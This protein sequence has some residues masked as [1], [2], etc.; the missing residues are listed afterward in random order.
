M[1]FDSIASTNYIIS[2]INLFSGYAISLSTQQ[3][4]AIVMIIFLTIINIGGLSMGKLIQNVFTLT[5]TASLLALILLGLF[6]GGRAGVFSANWSIPFSAADAGKVVPDLL[7]SL[8]PMSIVDGILGIVVVLGV[9]QVG[10]LFS[11]DAWNN[12]TFTAGE[13]KE[14]KRTIPLS[15]VLGTGLVLTLYVLANLAYLNTLPLADIQTTPEDRVG[16]AALQVIFGGVGAMIMAYA[17]V[18][19]TFGCNNGLI[20]SGARVYYA[21]AKD[22]LFFRKTG[23]LNDNHVPAFAL[24]LQCIWACVL[25][26]PRTVT[27]DDKG[28]VTYGNLYGA[29]LDY[30]VF[31]VLI[32]YILTIIGLFILRKK[33]P[34]A[35][36]PYKAFGYPVIPALYVAA[37]AVIC[38]VLLLY[39]TKTSLPGLA[40]VLTGV[41]VY[42]LWRRSMGDGNDDADVVADEQADDADESLPDIET[43]GEASDV[44]PTDLNDEETDRTN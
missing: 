21:M 41:P 16:T 7:S 24:I 29:L 43:E 28:A 14:P 33:R 10:S 26:L 40:I 2:P 35:D 32:F 38:I 25:V 4:I 8:S 13:V 17:I 3:F 39:K 15:L 1:F 34:D 27:V 9:A 6:I 18:V 22:K 23:E 30:V 12:I 44:L 36:R 11:S 5:K 42:Y 37:A 31:A 19:S 20:L